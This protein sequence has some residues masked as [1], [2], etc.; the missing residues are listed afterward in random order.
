MQSEVRYAVLGDVEA[1]LG[2]GFDTAFTVSSQIRFYEREELVD[3]IKKPED[4]LLL[5]VTRDTQAVGFLFCKIMSSHWAMLDSF[6]IEPRFRG[7][8]YTN[9]L[10]QFLLSE[11]KIRGIKYLSTLIALND[12]ELARYLERRHK[13]EL[14]RKYS[15]YELF[16]NVGDPNAR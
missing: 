14:A 4:N 10:I 2:L 6:Y 7:K 5:V 16:L 13:F 12:L 9:S 3:W 8:D 11:L 1:I 15:W